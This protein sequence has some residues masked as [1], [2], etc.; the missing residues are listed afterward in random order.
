M[1]DEQMSWLERRLSLS[2]ALPF[3]VA[4]PEG[5]FTV[6]EAPV[7]VN[8]F[9]ASTREKPVPQT[10]EIVNSETGE[11]ETFRLWRATVQDAASGD[12]FQV[13]FVAKQ[14]PVFPAPVFQKFRPLELVGLRQELRLN[15]DKCRGPRKGEQHQCRARIDR[16]YWAFGVQAPA[17]AGRKAA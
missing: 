10:V 2:E 8:D 16:S 7:Q 17:D 15:R 12:Q 6:D 3:E 1:A 13:H 5:A 11:Q 14:Q 4:F 9:E